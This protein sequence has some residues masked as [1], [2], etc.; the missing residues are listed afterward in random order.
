MKTLNV[1][2]DGIQMLTHNER[3]ASKLD[4]IAR[5]MSAIS[6]KRKKTDDDLAELARLEML[7]GVYE[8][9]DGLVGIPTW[10]VFKS[11]QEGARLN[12]LGRHIERGVL[13]MGS[14]I[15]PIKHDGPNT[16]RAMWEAGCFD[17]RSVK[18][19]TSKVT[20]TRPMFR[21][22]T[23]DVTFAIDTEI[24]RVDEFGMVAE[25]AGRLIGIG[26]YR[27]RFGRYEAT[28]T[29]GLV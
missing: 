12:K 6:S 18:V 16:A 3:L 22:W 27:P 13:P 26:D 9:E 11:L 28:I 8:T 7:G 24:I 19:G 14:D 1:R 2:L 4:P 29:E 25:N 5:E 10:N 15:A 17:Q 21:N 20:R 23:V